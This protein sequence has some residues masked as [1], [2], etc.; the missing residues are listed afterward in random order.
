MNVSK[1]SAIALSAA[2][3]LSLSASTAAFADGMP[4][5]EKKPQPILTP[6][7]EALKE[8]ENKEPPVDVTKPA[9]PPPAPIAE[10]AP[11]LPEPPAPVPESRIV[12]VQPNT[13]FFG[14]SVGMYD[15]FSH[16]EEA[17]S[18][19]LEWQPGVKIAGV[20]QPLFGAMVTTEGSL[21]GYGGVGVP[22]K[23]GKRVF[24][25][26]SVS[27]GAYEE[28]NGYDLD[29]TLAFRF[30]TELSYEFDN[31]SRLGINAHILTNGDSFDREDRTEIISLVYT[32]PLDVLSGNN[33][34]K[35]E[36]K[37]ESNEP[38][39][40]APRDKKP[41]LDISPYKEQVNN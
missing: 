31:K 33:K 28:G 20:L 4:F 39:S 32:T 29:S 9:E 12:E 30:G 21:L 14:L 35:M 36:E 27:V 13:S 34:A 17:A 25:M 6:L 23:L 7:D 5:K 22:F 26:P 18:F 41:A 37:K 40:Y 24:V 1:F 2:V 19:N 10:K 11:K 3:A 38:V 16:G 15:P 8:I